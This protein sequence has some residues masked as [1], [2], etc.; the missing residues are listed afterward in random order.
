M[1]NV[2]ALNNVL[3]T[4]I[5]AGGDNCA[6]IQSLAWGGFDRDMVEIDAVDIADGFKQY[7]AGHINPGEITLTVNWIPDNDTHGKTTTSLYAQ[8][9]GTGASQTFTITEPKGTGDATHT[10]PGI[11]SAF[12]RESSNGEVITATFT[13]KVAG[14][15]TLNA[16]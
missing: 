1:G 6:A 5:N 2:M 7:K 9:V 3:L 10:F 8:L 4:W 15:P 16:T 12:G 14:K 11:V 13:I